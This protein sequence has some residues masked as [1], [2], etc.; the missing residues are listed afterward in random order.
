MNFT[1]G[2]VHR[3]FRAGPILLGV[4][5]VVFALGMM[6]AADARAQNSVKSVPNAM[7]RIR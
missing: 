4:N 2:P 6:A 7:D 5:T 1:M 3:S